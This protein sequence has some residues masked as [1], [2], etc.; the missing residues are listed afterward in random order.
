MTLHW[1]RLPI[2]L[3]SSG[4]LYAQSTLTIFSGSLPQGTVGIPYSTTLL[5]S[6]GSLPYTWSLANGT[7]PP[8]LSLSSVN[9]FGT[10][11]G[12]PTVAGTFVITLRVTDAL[13]AQ[14]LRSVSIAIIPQPQL[15]ITTQ[16]LPAATVGQNYS[17]T[18]TAANGTA[19]YQW[20]AGQGVPPGLSL[21]AS[22]ILSGTPTT[23]GTYNFQV[24]VAD[25]AQHNAAAGLSITVNPAPLVITTVPPLF[26]GIVGVA[27]A[28]SFTASGGRTPY[29]WSILSGS[30][31]GLSLDPASGAL[32]GTPQ[33][34][35][36]F[37]LTIQ[38]TDTVGV[39]TSQTFSLVVNQPSLTLI[40][41]G[42]LPAG[43]VGV[44]YNQKIPATVSGGTPPYTW[45]VVGAPVPGLDF[46][47]VNI[48]LSGTPTV[49]GA[50]SVT[51][52][53]RDSAGQTSS[54]PFSLTIAPAALTIT[55]ARQ[56]PDST[57]NAPFSQQLEASGGV[58]P[59]NWLANGLPAGLS[60]DP[61][62][63]IISGASNAAGSFS[64]A[65]TVS[66][67]TLNRYSD[68]FS[69]N[70]A[71]PAI[72][73]VTITGLPAVAP[74]AQQFP[75]QIALAAP[76]PVP[77]TGQAILGF[78][79]NSGPADRTVLFASG[80]TTA[81]FTIPAGSTTPNFDSPLTL[82][83]GT[84]AGTITVS[85]RLQAGVTDITPTPVPSISTQIVADAP[86]VKSA[87]VTR[88]GNSVT[89]AVTGFSTAREITQAVFTFS[90]ATGQTLQ[91]G[92]SSITVSVESL[93]GNW[94]QDPTN[95]AYGSQ[96]VFSQTFQV[97]GDAANVI[98][99]S[100]TLTNRIGSSSATVNP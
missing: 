27:Y 6:G 25:A 4:L 56:L 78:A 17:Q 20:V 61:N 81:G 67:S 96:F 97:Q 68:R 53:V 57:F 36:T 47:A 1:L 66:D 43:G 35:G 50:F 10:I 58:P 12:T 14:A 60:I 73:S 9:S 64:F 39:K 40:S 42:Q 99:Q 63:G 65:I 19:P 8:G 44:A 5:A 41:S 49:A 23:F 28:Q 2:L 30:V 29:T 48:A 92:A 71:L 31:P 24:Q 46:D 84:V 37:S 11:A 94:F 51:V 52:Q 69:L 21:S 74:A 16:N 75:I 91:T 15:S 95:A 70:I 7:L 80:G 88:S 45:S 22:G 93:F 55:T 59:Y 86:V 87:Q 33:T 89:I 83:T 90:A 79:P 100:V 98:P 82:Q 54:R 13:Q 3:L 77:I 34:V 85:L 32:Q 72:P 18:L 38:V 26:S 76:F 62:T